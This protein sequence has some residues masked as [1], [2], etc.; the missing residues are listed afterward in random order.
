MFLFKTNRKLS[1]ENLVLMEDT[2]SRE[3]AAREASRENVDLQLNGLSLAKK[4]F[5]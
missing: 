5:E 1:G 3:S 4:V 2:E